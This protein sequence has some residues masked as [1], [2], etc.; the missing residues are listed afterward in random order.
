MAK[1]L[2][3]ARIPE[4]DALAYI[5]RVV[6]SVTLARREY[7][8]AARE[9]EIDVFGRPRV[10]SEMGPR[11]PWTRAS[12]HELIPREEL[13]RLEWLD[14]PGE[15]AGLHFLGRRDWVDREVRR[16]DIEACWPQPPAPGVA[17]RRRAAISALIDRGVRHDQQTTWLDIAR[18]VQAEASVKWNASGYS[19]KSIEDDFRAEIKRRGL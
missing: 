6:G 3:S 11:W 9:G 2:R 8:R 17:A 15:F 1:A 19:P 4:N 5:A 10:P 14:L 12:F 18:L 7:L 13:Y 16:A